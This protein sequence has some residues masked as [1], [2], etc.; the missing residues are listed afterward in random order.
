MVNI[1]DILGAELPAAIHKAL[2]PYS[3]VEV[4]GMIA[5][6]LFHATSP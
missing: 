1:Q 2:V 3:F 6:C 5:D 4:N